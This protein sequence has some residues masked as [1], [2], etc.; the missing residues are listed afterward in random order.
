MKEISSK[1]N[2]KSHTNIEKELELIGDDNLYYHIFKHM[3]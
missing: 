1:S 3:R 2:T